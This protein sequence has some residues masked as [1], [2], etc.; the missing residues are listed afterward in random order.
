MSQVFTVNGETFEV[1]KEIYATHFILSEASDLFEGVHDY[2]IDVA[3][4]KHTL[5]ASIELL[6]RWLNN[7]HENYK[8][9][10]VDHKIILLFADKYIIDA[11]ELFLHLFDHLT[12][13]YDILVTGITSFG[14]DHRITGHIISLL[15]PSLNDLVSYNEEHV[16]IKDGSCIET[17]IIMGNRRPFDFRSVIINKRNT[18]GTHDVRPPKNNRYSD[19]EHDAKSRVKRKSKKV[20]DYNSGDNSG[21]H[22]E[23]SN[24]KLRKMYFAMLYY[25]SET[26]S[27]F[28][29][30]DP[31]FELY[32]NYCYKIED[33][34][35]D[36]RWCDRDQLMKCAK[37]KYAECEAFDDDDACHMR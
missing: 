27:R 31:T 22:V 28:L 7:V 20:L 25:V 8:L 19:D 30:Y 14:D 26:H 16:R 34:L 18:S 5:V 10:Y 1:T 13:T 37:K 15:E 32:F 36:D 23:V 9:S 11:R 4:D 17:K 29:C 6:L 24:A 21:T 35:S 33:L 12:Y 3:T 2:T